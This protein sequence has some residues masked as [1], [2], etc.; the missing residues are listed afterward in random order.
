MTRWVLSQR[1]YLPFESTAVSNRFLNFSK[2]LRRAYTGFVQNLQ[3]VGSVLLASSYYAKLLSQCCASKS[4][5]QGKLAHTQ[6]TKFGLSEDPKLR[7]HL[8]TLYSKCRDFGY[9]R[10]LVDESPEPDL[11][12]WSA[13]ISGFAQNEHGQEAIS[14]YR[15]M[16]GMG[17]MGNEFTFP[18]VLKSCSIREDLVMGKQVHGVVVVTGHD[19]D[20]FV[21][22]GLV[23]MYAK[24]GE[25]GDSRRV[26]CSIQVK[27]VVSWNG[28]I[29]SYVQSDF[30]G[31]AKEMFDKMILSGIR[32]S[33]FSLSSILNAC[34]G[35][36][37]RSQGRKVHGYLIKLGYESDRFSENAL[38][39]MYAKAGDLEDA[40]TAFEEISQPDIV[41]WNA[42]IAG[43]VLHEQNHQALKLYMQM[44]RSG[45]FPNLFTLS[46]ALKAC[47][48]MEL[49]YL[50]RQLH[51]IVMKLDTKADNF[52]RA[53]L[54]DMYSKCSLM[55]DARMAFDLMAQKDLIAL[56]A[57]ISGYSQNG[58][59]VQA[60]SLFAETYKS[61]IGFNQTTLSVI[62]KSATSMQAIDVSMQVHALSSKLGFDNDSQVATSLIDAYSKCG[63]IG[64][65]AR[66]FE[67]CAA[68]D[69]VAL[70]SMI[71]AYAQ[72]GQ[73]EEAVKLYLEVQRRG[74]KPDPFVCSSL[75]NASANLSAYEQGKQAHVHVLKFGFMS[76]V[77]AGNSLVNMY[78]KCGSIDDAICAFDEIPLRGI[79]SW[80]AMIGGFAQ[81]G[82]GKEAL[83]LFDQMLEDGVAPNHIT[84]LSVL[85]ACNHAGLV[86]KAERFFKSMEESFAIRHTQEHYACMIDIL[87]RAGKLEEAV[88]LIE[89]MPFQA[90]GHVWGA[91]LGA[92]RIHKNVELGKRAAE[93]LFVVE[94]ENSGTHVLLSNIYA[95]AGMWGNVAEVRRLMKRS[96]VKK[97]PGT[98]W[99]EL[100]DKVYTFIVGDRN[101]P[102]TEEIYAKLDELSELMSRAGYV[103]MVEIDLHDVETSEKEKLLC[104]HSEKLA[105]AFA[106]IA[107][108]P[109]APIR[110]KKNLRICIDCHNAFK[111]ICKIVSRE[112]IIRDT[113]RFHHFRNG[114]C[115]CGDYW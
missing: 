89:T 86:D 90:T 15:E 54:V 29:S 84:L 9:A 80:S 30:F 39:D 93:M 63:N 58:E 95:S 52:V 12:S 27:N 113:N 96:K 21:A 16:H 83:Q 62:L 43:C 101:H 67:F 59:D 104:H 38:V 5:V 99:V 57:L 100:K 74:L 105:V 103:P 23:V 55:E 112:I 4:L 49:N 72:C 32:P 35:L 20:E 41:S 111:F 18:T 81:H 13:L 53:G 115:S 26:F 108:P 19:S 69:L 60:V 45:I 31:E 75:L 107:S 42:I 79:V 44:N 66:A 76:D 94:P 25:F 37:D 24:C 109:G 8:I 77:F 92:A 48:G 47:A 78:A 7:I 46:S 40:I 1:L 102:R 14:A 91:I 64:E 2:S 70:T 87:G 68:G 98:S 97:E 110:V 17:L 65:A 82:H 6:L 114:S 71:A 10:K 85:C 28:L 51:S 73:G 61:E 34:A 50:A 56:N 3:N 33:E 11:V 88:D 36:G 22:N 106:L